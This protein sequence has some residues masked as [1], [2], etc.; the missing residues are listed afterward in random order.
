MRLER[1]S[2]RSAALAVC[3]AACS[4]AP[5][6][7]DQPEASDVLVRLSVDRCNGVAHEGM[8]ATRI[9]PG[10]AATVA[11]GFVDEDG[12]LD[13]DEIVATNADGGELDARLAFIDVERDVAL[14]A[15]TGSKSYLRLASA[16][17]LADDG[18]VQIALFEGGSVLR[19]AVELEAVRPISV[20]GAGERQA[21]E[22]SGTVAPGD[23]GA[24]ALAD[25]GR[26]L[27]IVFASGS[28]RK[29]TWA[30]AA[31]EYEAAMAQPGN[32]DDLSC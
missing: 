2:V 22:L 15:V 30:I 1:R 16:D 23:S 6:S 24:P 5:G 18:S 19:R 28:G 7:E 26:L 14:L 13:V 31:P 3:A 29:V 27:G 21:L 32:V 12:N 20:D 25:D 4:I 8:V 11:H 10:L 9:G 17:A